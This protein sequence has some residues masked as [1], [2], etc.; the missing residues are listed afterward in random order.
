[1]QTKTQS[2]DNKYKVIDRDLMKCLA[3]I[4]MFIGH[5]IAWIHL[6][7]D[8]DNVYA[9]YELPTALLMIS[10]LSLFCPPVMFFFV[11]DGYKYTRDWK[12]YAVRL[13]LFALV[14]QPF[15]WLIFQP[16][17]GWW[18]SNVIF[19]L[20][21][22]LLSIICWESKFK[23]WKR[24]LLITLCIAATVLIYSDWLVFGVL[25]ILFLHIFRD[26]PRLRL[27]AYT[28]LALV[29][30][31]LNLFSLGKVPAFKL[32]TYSAVMF[33]VI[34]AAYFCM[35]TFYNGQKGKH[36]TFIKWFFYAFYP[37]HYLI[38]W[39]IRICIDKF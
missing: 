6:M 11:A 31:L 14:T 10:G 26:R 9:F 22:G 21:F 7:N 2:G 12:K 23:L 19:T 29:H 34:M 37:A 39:C 20:F 33:A 36:P 3:V 5:A 35:T 17:Q 32:I 24:I 16:I 18:T 13:L 27:T 8:P 38:I 28:S 1:M 30:C 15:D 4:P 25:F